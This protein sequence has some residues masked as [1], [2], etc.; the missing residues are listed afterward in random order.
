[1]P[2]GSGIA[3]AEFGL[4]VILLQQRTRAMGKKPAAIPEDLKRWIEARQ[5]HRLSHVH[6]QMARELGLN[7]R[8][9]GKIDN[10]RQEPWKAP[11]PDFIERIYFK[12]FRKEKPDKIRTIEEIAAAQ[13]AKQREKKLAEQER[14]AAS[15]RN[16]AGNSVDHPLPLPCMPEPK[17]GEVDTADLP[18]SSSKAAS[19]P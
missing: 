6:I 12:R 1:M 16:I 19:A 8:K 10:H 17:Q 4:C 7:P 5:R 11:L 18:G 9:F 13:A 3:L 14:K 2:A 15:A